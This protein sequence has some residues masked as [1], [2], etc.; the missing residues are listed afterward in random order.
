M[1]EYKLQLFKDWLG[2]NNKNPLVLLKKNRVLYV[3]NGMSHVKAD[4]Q[5]PRRH[6]L[7]IPPGLEQKKLY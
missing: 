7:I 6:F 3:R 1:A 4:T 5:K 2:A